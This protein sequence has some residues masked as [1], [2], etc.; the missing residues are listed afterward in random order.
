LPKDPREDQEA[1]ALSPVHA[2]E[3]SQ[4]FL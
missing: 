2:N 4:L 1:I 3:G